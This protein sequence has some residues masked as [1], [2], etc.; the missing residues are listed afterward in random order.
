MEKNRMF[1]VMVKKN[2]SDS[3]FHTLDEFLREWMGVGNY[4]LYQVYQE[5]VDEYEETEY[6]YPSKKNEGET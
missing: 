6:E 5:I 1:T 3:A 2:D 4:T